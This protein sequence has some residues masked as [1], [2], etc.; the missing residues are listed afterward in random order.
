MQGTL[1]SLLSK[2]AF[3]EQNS[4]GQS[5]AK[6]PVLRWHTAK[7]MGGSSHS[8][9]CRLYPALELLSARGTNRHALH[10]KRSLS[11]GRRGLEKLVD[12]ITVDESGARLRNFHSGF[13]LSAS[14]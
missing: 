7:R 8:K 6:A 10:V 14:R 12:M 2:A 3:E 4:W 11:R 5:D 13:A 9:T 1:D